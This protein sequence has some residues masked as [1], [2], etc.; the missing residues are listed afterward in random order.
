MSTAKWI[1]LPN[2]IFTN[3]RIQLLLNEPRGEKIVLCYL[4]LLCRASQL[5]CNGSFILVKE[6]YTLKHFQ[7]VMNTTLSFTKT[8]IN[9]LLKYHLLDYVNGVFFIPDWYEFESENRLE[10]LRAYDRERKRKKRAEQKAMED[11]VRWTQEGNPYGN[12]NG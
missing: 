1:Q 8:V 7:I 6:P 11:Y 4:R 3:P 10:K 9:L 12:S 5:E 2:D